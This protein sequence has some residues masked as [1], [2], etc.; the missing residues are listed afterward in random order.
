MKMYFSA[1]RPDSDLGRVIDKDGLRVHL[2]LDALLDK[3]RAAAKF[4]I[5]LAM[6]R[7][8]FAKQGRPDPAP[9]P[10]APGPP[11]PPALNTLLQVLSE[12]AMGREPSGPPRRAAAAPAAVPRRRRVVGPHHPTVPESA[13][14]PSS[15]P[16]P[17]PFPAP[18]IGQPLAP[19]PVCCPQ[20][21]T[22]RA[23]ACRSTRT[24]PSPAAQR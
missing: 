14:A 17:P 1:S 6:M 4:L 11:R 18:W 19:A 12:V 5:V 13:D 24:T 3:F 2:Y 23:S 8:W 15:L 22:S 20:G 21:S 16:A 10:G 7:S 9:D